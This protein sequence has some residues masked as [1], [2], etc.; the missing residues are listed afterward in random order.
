MDKQELIR[1][2][3]RLPVESRKEIAKAIIQSI[4]RDLSAPSAEDRLAELITVACSA[5]GV[6]DYNPRRK[7]NGDAYVRNFC[8]LTM[9]EEGYTLL[10]IGR[11]MGRHTSSVITMSRRGDE[12]RHGYFGTDI[13][14]RYKKFNEAVQSH[15]TND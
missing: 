15:A 4:D 1:A 5:L 10:Q 12:M 8:A 9:R 2:A 7:A 6:T 13:L 11:A 3:R 14:A